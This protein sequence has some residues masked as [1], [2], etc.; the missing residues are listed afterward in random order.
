MVDLGLALFLAIVAAGIGKRLLRGVGV[1]PEHPFD[2]LALAVPLG[3]GLMALACLAIG[4]LGELNLA[5]LTVLLAVA[6]EIGLFAGLRLVRDAWRDRPAQPGELPETPLDRLLGGLL[7]LSIATTAV[8]AMVPVT[9]GDALCYHLQVPKVFL[10]RRAVYFDPDLHETV[11]PLV[12]EMLYAFGL[13]F[14]GPIACRLIQWVLGLVFAANVTALARPSLG[15]RASWAGL[16]A[17]LVPAVTGGMAAPL[18]DVALAAFGT[19]AIVAWTRHAERRTA[20]TALLAGT[21]CG[22]ALGV[23]YPALVLTGL[24]CGLTTI[25]TWIRRSSRPRGGWAVSIGHGAAFL[26]M[27]VLVGG[28]WYLRAYIHTGNPVYPFFRGWFGGAGLDE[29]LAPIKRPLPVGFWNLVTSLVP[30]SIEPHRFDSFAHQFGPAFLLFL[31]ALFLERAPRRVIGL[32]IIGYLFLIVCMSQR[33]SMRFLLIGLGPMSVGVAFLACRWNDRGTIPA[34]LLTAA[35]VAVLC[36]EAGLATVRAGRAMGVVLGKETFHEFLG[37]CEPTYRVGSWVSRNLP[38]AARLIGQDHRGFYI[39]RAYTM[40]LAHRRRTGLGDS[41]ESPREI[42][43]TLKKEGYTH[44]MLC[45]PVREQA[46]EFDPTLG[47]LLSPWLDG[48]EPVYREDLADAEGVVRRY[49]IYE[50]IDQGVGALK[51]GTVTR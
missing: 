20:K 27:A 34:R 12:C 18:N 10:I 50:L 40:E 9:D 1:L 33:Q 7:L 39:P 31:P 41:G 32:A 49:A 46:V 24:L 43:E 26:G 16:V 4:E 23:K 42:V 8:A 28:G 48:R 21:F 3:L 2:A 47:R 19:A 44:L 13:E 11:Y 37:R 25:Q 35:V 15:R 22:L 51:S 17:L 45:P 6:A 5:G 36:L 29:V 38:A 14:R 30:L